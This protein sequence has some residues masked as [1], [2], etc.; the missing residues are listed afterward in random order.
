MARSPIVCMLATSEA[1]TS[2]AK[3]TWERAVLPSSVD[4]MVMT[5]CHYKS[6]LLERQEQPPIPA[7]PGWPLWPMSCL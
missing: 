7:L 1:A 3:H 4:L 6:A 2:Q 5:A